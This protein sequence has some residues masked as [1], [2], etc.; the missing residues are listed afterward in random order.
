MFEQL[1]I[2]FSNM[3]TV[4]VATLSLVLLVAFP[5][6]VAAG[7]TAGPSYSGDDAYDQAAGGFAALST[8]S[9]ASYSGDDAYDPAAGGR[10]A[11]SGVTVSASYSGD[12][13]YD[14]A[15]GGLAAVSTFSFAASQGEEAI[16][17]LTAFASAGGLSGDDAY[18]PAAG[19]NP[20]GVC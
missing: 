8:R 7:H 19:G 16:C 11:L 14:P 18:D 10:A 12:D 3:R 4:V 5:L 2:R 13:A 17:G 6:V 1:S 9:S 15:A 20:E